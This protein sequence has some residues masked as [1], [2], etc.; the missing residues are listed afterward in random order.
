MAR[1]V[2]KSYLYRKPKGGSFTELIAVVDSPDFGGEPETV[3]VTTQKYTKRRYINGL[4]D[5][6]SL[7][8]TAWYTLDDVTTL[9]SIKEADE[10]ISDPDDLATY[11][12]LVGDDGEHG[13][14]EWQGKLDWYLNSA[15]P[16]DAQQISITISD[17]GDTEMKWY[18]APPS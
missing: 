6:S 11:R 5:S 9:Q 13:C 18:A 16:G 14:Y 10:S 7:T 3:D 1:L 2:N 15:A 4:Q 12:Y 17:E 8:F